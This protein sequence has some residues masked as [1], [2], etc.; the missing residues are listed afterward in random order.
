MDLCP[1]LNDVADE[2]LE[3][4]EIEALY[5]TYVERQ[6]RDAAALARD[7]AQP[8]PESLNYDELTGLSAELRGKLSQIRPRNLAQAGRID[9]MTPAALA[10]ILTRIRRD[11]RKSA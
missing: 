2:A 10:L 5:A 9:G 4:L 11:T 8:I 7:E 6:E 1:D 3:Q